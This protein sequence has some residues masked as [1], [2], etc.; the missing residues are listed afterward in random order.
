MKNFGYLF[1]L[2]FLLISSC[3]IGEPLKSGPANNNNTYKVDYL[4]EHDGCKVYRFF[5][6]LSGSY[7]YFTKTPGTVT[8]IKA[9]STR[10]SITDIVR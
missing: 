4:F 1:F 9:D 5:D 3:K 8:S 7:V 2:V 10:R 6:P